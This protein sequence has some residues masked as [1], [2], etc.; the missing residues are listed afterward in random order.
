M[1]RLTA[2]L[3]LDFLGG[4][5]PARLFVVVH[6]GQTK[7]VLLHEV[8]VL[9]HFEEQVLTFRPFLR[10]QNQ[11]HG[12]GG[13]SLDEVSPQHSAISCDFI[14]LHVSPIKDSI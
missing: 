9:A 14:K 8:E 3:P 12:G 2:Y 13:I 11:R 4:V 10:R 7:V 1:I 5:Q 6:V